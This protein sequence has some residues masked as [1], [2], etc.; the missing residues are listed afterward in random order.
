MIDLC[1]Y[2]IGFQTSRLAAEQLISPI[3][4]FAHNESSHARYLAKH[5]SLGESFIG[6]DKELHGVVLA[7]AEDF[8]YLFFAS[9]PLDARRC[10]IDALR[11]GTDSVVVGG[12]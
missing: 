8:L 1:I 4:L 7:L 2:F 6:A 11:I 9:I 12:L 3:G 5:G 10:A